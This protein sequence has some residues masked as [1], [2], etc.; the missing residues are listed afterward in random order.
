MQGHAAGETS[1]D[2]ARMPP[3]GRTGRWGL[4][5]KLNALVLGSDY[6]AGGSRKTDERSVP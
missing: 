2:W 1:G 5:K 3:V 6:G 4:K